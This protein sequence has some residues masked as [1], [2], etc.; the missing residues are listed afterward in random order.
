ME[1]SVRQQHNTFVAYFRVSTAKQGESGLGLDAQR[2][3]VHD[4]CSRQ[5]VEIGGEFVEI[6]SGRKADRPELERAL[7]YCRKHKGKLLIAKLDRLA[8][9][10]HVVSGLMESGVSFLALDMPQA[11]RFMLH[12]YAAMAEE[13]ARRISQR[14]KAALAAAKARG[15]RLGANGAALAETHAADADAFALQVGPHLAGLQE[16]GAS[17]RSASQHLNDRDIKAFGGGRWH[18]TSVARTLKRY[19]ALQPIAA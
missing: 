1:T 6:E 7:S 5:G 14:T 17:I 10:V 8:R 3:T 13:E 19:R 11:D 18:P 4:F 9:N 15:T 12:V 16:E 2:A